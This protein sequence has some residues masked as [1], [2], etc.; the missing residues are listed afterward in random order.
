M[1]GG[2]VRPILRGLAAGRG[3]AVDDGGRDLDPG[4]LRSLAF[5]ALHARERR[6]VDLDAGDLLV[7]VAQHPRAARRA[8]PASPS[9]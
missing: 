3:S 1:T 9:M 4:G 5:E 7:H 8:F 2:P 6:V